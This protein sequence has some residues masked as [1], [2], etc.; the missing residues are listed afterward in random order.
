MG[1]ALRDQLLKAGLVNEKQVKQAAKDKRKE[2]QRMQG[3]GRSAELDQEN[4]RKQQAQAEKIE[5]DRKLNQQR[6]QQAEQ[7]ALAAQVRQIVE[8][9]RLPKGDSDTPYNFVDGGKVKRL[10]IAD[11]A[12]EQLA[13]GLWA[14]VR[15]DKR[16]EL[17]TREIALKIRERDAASVAV[18]NEPV[19]AKTAE[20]AD[21]PYAQ[22]QIP[23]DLMW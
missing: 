23:D 21:D 5:R 11:E 18:L 10:Y 4:R 22:Y 13:K 6:Q 2:E 3:Q 7:K 15:M 1:N 12:R 16:Y 20:S 8:Q 17:V 19:Q 14:I 9:N